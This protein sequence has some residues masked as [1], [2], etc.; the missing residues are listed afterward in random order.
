MGRYLF[1]LTAEVKDDER[2][3]LSR[4]GRFVRVLDPGL[5]RIFDA[6][7]A[8]AVEFFKVV[9]TTFPIDRIRLLQSIAPDVVERYFAVVAAK[10]DE[11]IFVMLD[12][13]TK[14]YITPRNPSAYWKCVTRVETDTVSVKDSNRADPF[15]AERHGVTRAAIVLDSQIESHEAGLLFVDGVLS[16]KLAPGRHMF[17]QLLRKIEVRKFDLRA[18]PLEVT[19]QEILTKDRVGLR[20]TLTAFW[21]IVDP[22]RV[23]VAA[24]DL[25][26]LIYR[27]IQ[28]AIREA[29]VT[30]TLDEILGARDAID[31][32]IRSYVAAR[33]PELGIAI[34]E[35]GLKD[36]ILPGD[37]RA[38]LN[39][40]VEADRTARANL[41]RRQEE[42][43]A[44]R[45]LLNTARLME[46][47]PTLLRLKELESLERLV[48]KVGRIDLHAGPGLS[49]F[50][51]LLKGLY[52][53][54]PDGDSASGAQRDA[55]DD[56][57]KP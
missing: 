44:T 55:P 35:F 8:Y 27:L 56:V 51:P 7:H 23:A 14:F 34:G 2:A 5:H 28:F 26:N 30:R 24:A 4:N 10:P 13:E 32:E 39:K 18:Q 54:D 33:A 37:V 42:T 49:A 48:E 36:V 20:I 45:S 41:I 38:L 43:A 19:A 15:V 9:G 22:E 12:G 25:A 29:V 3:F 21:H 57:A 11:I 50:E 31:A 1:Y 17:W 6:S 40:V 47:N 16:E 46:N 52:R 53:L